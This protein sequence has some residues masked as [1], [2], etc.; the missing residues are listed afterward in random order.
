ML[1]LQSC[2]CCAPL[3]WA[4]TR[5]IL[6]CCE[7]VQKVV[8]VTCASE[9]TM[10]VTDDGKVYTWGRGG[11]GQLGLGGTQDRLVPEEVT[12]LVAAT[13]MRSARSLLR[14]AE[15]A[16]PALTAAPEA[17]QPGSQQARGLGKVQAAASSK[18]GSSAHNQAAARAGGVADAFQACTAGNKVEHELRHGADGV[19]ARN[20]VDGVLQDHEARWIAVATDDGSYPSAV[21]YLLRRI[22]VDRDLSPI[23]EPHRLRE[24]AYAIYR[25]RNKIVEPDAQ[26]LKYFADQNGLT[27]SDATRWR[28]GNRSKWDK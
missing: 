17:K 19:L 12:G 28:P 11:G 14:R 1:A 21:S 23:L 7:P 13:L 10:C 5:Q 20:G 25:Y 8:D 3:F 2:E 9:H 18:G 27:G 16:S 15:T 24:L 26:D 6:T 4:W 22:N